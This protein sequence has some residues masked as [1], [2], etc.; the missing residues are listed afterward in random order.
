MS[1]FKEIDKFYSHIDLFHTF[2]DSIT[3][4]YTK[5]QEMSSAERKTKFIFG[6][7]CTPLLLSN[8]NILQ[9][10]IANQG[11]EENFTIFSRKRGANI[12]S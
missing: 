10:Q 6:I 3:I 12:I 11:N 1:F 4:H 7:N 9:F 2:N 5:H 8:I